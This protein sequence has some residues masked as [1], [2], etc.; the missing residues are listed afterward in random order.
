MHMGTGNHTIIRRVVQIGWDG[1]EELRLDIASP[2]SDT[3][4]I[5]LYASLDSPWANFFAG[6]KVALDASKV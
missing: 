4:D 2:G 3:A 5:H 6:H 1:Q